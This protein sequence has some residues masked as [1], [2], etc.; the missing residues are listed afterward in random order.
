MTK[1]ELLKP[2]YKVMANYPYTPFGI[3]DIITLKDEQEQVCLINHQHIDEFGVRKNANSIFS[4]YELNNYPH[5]FKPLHW[6]EERELSELPEYI[7][8]A[9][10]YA[11]FKKDQ[12]FKT[13][14]WNKQ[15]EAAGYCIGFLTGMGEYD[16]CAVPI[17]CG[18]LPATKDEYD[19]YIKRNEVKDEDK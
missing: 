8:F 16:K 10:D 13:E 11:G 12:V 14:N 2:R 9:K 1:E 17:S 3:G 6:W 18:L 15:N 7:M 4:I 19:E 5:L